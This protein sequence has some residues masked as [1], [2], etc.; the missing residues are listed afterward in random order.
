MGSGIKNWNCV[1]LFLDIETFK[2][3]KNKLVKET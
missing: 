1:F 3:K 2:K